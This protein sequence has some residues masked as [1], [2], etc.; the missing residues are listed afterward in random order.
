MN[1]AELLSTLPGLES[2]LTGYAE[3]GPEG[4]SFKLETDDYEFRKAA[5]SVRNPGSMV[6]FVDDNGENSSFV[7]IRLT[8]D[9]FQFVKYLDIMA[10]P[11]SLKSAHSIDVTDEY[12]SD[13]RFLETVRK[14]QQ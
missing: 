11:G 14:Y 2:A 5:E 7:A 3:L 13:S 9:E 4:L 6:L 10:E 8:D 12:I 1:W